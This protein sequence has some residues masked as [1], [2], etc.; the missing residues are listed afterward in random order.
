M[1]RRW[2]VGGWEFLNLFLNNEKDLT[3]IIKN[4]QNLIKDWWSKP[5]QDKKGSSKKGQK[6]SI[7]KNTQNLIK[8]QWLK[9]SQ[10]KKGS[11]KKGQKTHNP[12]AQKKKD[13]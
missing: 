7:I 5:S 4:T 3:S 10:D 12:Q 1:H 13:K 6:T 9:P 8:D 2:D 11:P